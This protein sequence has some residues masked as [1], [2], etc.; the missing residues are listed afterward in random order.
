MYSARIYLKTPSNDA[1]PVI[2]C[3]S[4]VITIA[5]LIV[6]GTLWQSGDE[7]VPTVICKL[8]IFMKP[9]CVVRAVPNRLP[10]LKETLIQG[11]GAVI[12]AWARSRGIL[13]E[14]IGLRPRF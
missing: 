4:C 13:F 2:W 3:S 11:G 6:T 12:W 10:R 1:L 14:A 8:Q 9:I 5:Y 7:G